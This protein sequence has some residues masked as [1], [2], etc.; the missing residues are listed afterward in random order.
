[1]K[2]IYA[3][4]LVS[5]GKSLALATILILV[6]SSLILTES[7][8]AQTIPKP[9]VPEFTA[10]YVDRS[11]TVPASG[12]ENSWV[13]K[14]S[15][16]FSRT[17][18]GAAAVT[19]IVY[20]IGGS[21]RYN[22]TGTGFSYLSINATE[23]YNPATDTWTLKM[24]MPTSR[25]G[26]GV[27]V[28]Q[29]KIYCIGGRSASATGS[30][31]T[32]ANEVYDTETDSWQ[33]KTSMPTARYGIEA[34]VVDGK[35]YLIGGYES[36]SIPNKSAK[37]E[38]YD[39]VTD[40]WTTGSPLP[41]AV[42]E[43]ASAVVDGK[44]YV[45]SGSVSESAMTNLTQIYDPKTDKW[46]LGAP[47]PMSVSAAA[48]GATTGMKAVKAIYVFGGANAKY[49]LNGQITNQVYFSETN[50][51]SMA[52]S[53]PIDRAGSAV[54]VVNDT[55][56]VMGGGHNI[57]FSDSTVVM[58][59]APFTNPTVEMDSFPVLPVVIAFVV[60]VAVVAVGIL[61]YLKKHKPKTG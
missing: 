31:A 3:I 43:Y 12:A 24:P 16:H 11:Y 18:A 7:A 8:F 33:T 15:M 47:I 57:F 36:F 37:V 46:S 60:A 52:A 54:A 23:A 27:A 34:N 4:V 51:W 5:M 32:N 58:Q 35:F 20:V 38:V 9:S 22:V 14:T 59:Y 45:I 2:R 21:Q 13:T 25:D 19:G 41:T 6:A 53:M 10:K 30:Q 56:Y 17:G 61:V 55:F 48:A 49:P 50:S 39:P 44:V 29:N 42:G 1:M 26:F 40:T 28:Y